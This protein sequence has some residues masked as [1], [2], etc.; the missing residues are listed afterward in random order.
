MN[1]SPSGSSTIVVALVLMFLGIIAT[2]SDIFPGV[3]LLAL[4][5]WMLYKQMGGKSDLGSVSR[6]Y[7]DKRAKAAAQAFVEESAAVRQSGSEK[8]YA[9]ALH[10]V[11]QAGLNPDQMRV[12]PVD[13]GFMV[14]RANNEAD[15]FR[16]QPLPDDADYIQPFVQL[17][18]ST[19]ARGRVKFEI[20]DSDGRTI[21]IHEDIHELARGRNLITPKA[22]LPIHDA[23]PMTHDWHLR[24]SADGLPL[25][26]LE[27]GWSESGTRY[28]RRNISEDGEISNELR[29][30][31]AENRLQE[32]VSLD[33]LLS[34]QQDE[35]P[36]RATRR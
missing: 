34:P 8:V 22:R 1:N 4:G 33:D 10:A 17:R 36:K 6:R 35:E 24:V 26:M 7:G 23:H 13:M 16:T 27:F 29:A 25:A 15:L 14:F 30:A 12:L 9:H 5:A 3:L 19:R 31:L 20:M 21:F 32:K 11:E 28:M 2:G 18:L